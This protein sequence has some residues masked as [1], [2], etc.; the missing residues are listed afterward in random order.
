[1]YVYENTLTEHDTLLASMTRLIL[2]FL[3]VYSWIQKSMHFKG[4]LLERSE[5]VKKWNANWVNEMNIY[6]YS[7]QI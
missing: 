5:D 3:F 2:D 7:G 1:M 6:F 4:S